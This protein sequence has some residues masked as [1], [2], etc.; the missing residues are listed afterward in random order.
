MSQ[1]NLG[2]AIPARGG[3]HPV[4]P[5]SLKFRYE[6]KE[7]VPAEHLPFYAEREGAFVLEVEGAVDPSSVAEL[8]RADKAKL[9]E[10]RQSN[11]A[12][13]KERDELRKRF[14]GIDPD[15]VQKLAEDKRK[16]E[17]EQ[18]LKAGEFEKVLEKRLTAIKSD[19][20]KTVESL[21]KERDGLHARIHLLDS[22]GQI[23]IE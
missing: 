11:V 23:G 10:F 9:D 13:L 19:H 4:I 2:L 1:P 5:M 12:L 7:D 20:D 15:E 18:Q 8:R 21:T 16:L 17:E 22:P 14:E 6:S 3:C